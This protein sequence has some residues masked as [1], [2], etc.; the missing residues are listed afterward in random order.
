MKIDFEIEKNSYSPE[1]SEKII[2]GRIDIV[3]GKGIQIAKEDLWKWFFK[4][5]P[6]LKNPISKKSHPHG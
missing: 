5:A 4:S 3:N 2:Q 6:L 1:F